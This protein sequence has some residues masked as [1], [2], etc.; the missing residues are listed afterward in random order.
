M[1]TLTRKQKNILD[2]WYE[3]NK[4]ALME[5]GNGFFNLA[6]CADFP[7]ELLERLQ[8]INDT[9]VLH[10]EIN[11]YISDKTMNELYNGGK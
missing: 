1:R 10:Q 7:F 2:K 4:K 8:E 5:H 11:R 9:E 6:K 3:E